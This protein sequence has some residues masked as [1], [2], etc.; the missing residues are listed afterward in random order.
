MARQRGLSLPP[1]L[2]ESDAGTF[3]YGADFLPITAQSLFHDARIANIDEQPSI[4]C[5]VDALQLVNND[6]LLI[7]S[8]DSIKKI[9][10]VTNLVARGLWS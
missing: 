5:F 2:I 9:S 7:K 4:V 6:D 1:S 3:P 10:I 8:I